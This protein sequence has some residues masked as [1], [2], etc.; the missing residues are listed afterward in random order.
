VLET[1]AAYPHLGKQIHL[2]LQSGDDKVLIRMN[3][4]Y[5]LEDY[6]RVVE[7]IR[8]ILPGATLFTDI[9]VGFC[10]ETEEQ[11]E[12]TRAAMRE[13]RYNM[14][15]IAAYSPRPGA[16]SSRWAD[17]VSGEEK[18]RRLHELSEELKATSTAAN[19][20]LVG[21]TV[22]ALVTGPDRKRGFL[23]ARTEGRIPARL[24]AVAGLA[25]GGMVTL[26]VSRAAALSLEGE[27][28]AGAREAALAVRP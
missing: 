19:R 4:S 25:P 27:E 14:A 3:R 13:F 26:R 16:A 18:K 21:S 1:I 20:A 15:Y 23:A 2:P 24:P 6:R 10:G 12:A 7:S 9:I 11:F 8:R 17:D 5:R 28:A 22:R